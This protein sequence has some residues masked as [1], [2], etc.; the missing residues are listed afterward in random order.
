VLVGELQGFGPVTAEY[1]QHLLHNGAA[2]PPPRR[3]GR[4]P[5]PA[6]AR[7]H[8]P[9]GWLD[10]EIR[11]RDGTCR[12][13]GCARAAHRVDLDHTIPFPRGP[14]IAVNLGGLCRRHHNL[15]TARVWRLDQAVDGTAAM[16]W[17]SQLTGRA[18]ITHPRG[19]TGDWRGTTSHQ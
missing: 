19:Q 3:S 18:Y 6:Q 2:V 4:E 10:T 14:T 13:P 15:K 8:D 7:T 1:A 11:A 12:Y 5:T 9:P 16:T 17:T